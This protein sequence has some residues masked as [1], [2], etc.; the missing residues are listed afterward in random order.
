M[1]FVNDPIA[2][3]LI[4]IKNAGAVRKE[5]V[6][7]PYSKHKHAIADAL[8]RAGFVAGVEKE[9]KGVKKVLKIRLAY[10]EKG[11]PKIKEVKRISKPGRRMYRKAKEI[12]PVKYGYG[13]AVLSTPKGVLTDQEARKENV[14]GE[15]LFELF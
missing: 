14:G 8:L 10:T 15:I 13:L 11:L 7:V 1:T 2:D 3:L 9:G 12:Y 6:K 5:E 4:R